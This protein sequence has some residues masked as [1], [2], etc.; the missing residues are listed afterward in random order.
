MAL[1][2]LESAPITRVCSQYEPRYVY[3]Y[4]Y[5]MPIYA[6]SYGGGTKTIKCLCLKTDNESKC[7]TT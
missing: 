7:T 1:L 2:T 6:A 3:K 4:D 5:E